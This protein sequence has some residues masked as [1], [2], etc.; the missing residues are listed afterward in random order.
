MARVANVQGLMEDLVNFKNNEPRGNDPHDED[1]ED[2]IDE[3]DDFWNVL[4]VK[5]RNRE[6]K[7]CDESLVDYRM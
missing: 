6:C 3:N 1:I 2:E 4:V 7:R 5:A